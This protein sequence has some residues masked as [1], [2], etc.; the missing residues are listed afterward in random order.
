MNPKE[1]LEWAVM[2]F[3]HIDEANAAMHCNMVKYSPITFAMAQ[4]LQQLGGSTYYMNKIL[5]HVGQYELDSGR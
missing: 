5:S 1:A 4:A 3:Y 2:H